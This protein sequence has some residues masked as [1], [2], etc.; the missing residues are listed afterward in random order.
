MKA[1]VAYT[2]LFVL[3]FLSLAPATYAQEQSSSAPPSQPMVVQPASSQLSMD[4]MGVR[5]YLL[6]PGDTLDVRVFGQPEMNWQGEVDSDGNLASLPFVEKPIRAQCRTDKD[7]EKDIR[8]AYAKFLKKP[9]VSV[10]VTGRNS[11]AP[12]LVYGA[13][14]VPQR[15]QMQRRTRL[16]EIFAISG[17]TTERSNG[18][19]LITH[20]QAILCPEPGDEAEQV[21]SDGLFQLS[22]KIYNVADL[23][24]GREDSNPYIRP[25]DVV[26]ALEAEPVYVNGSVIS[27]QGVFLTEGLRLQRALAMVGGVRKDAKQSAIVIYRVNPKGPNRE[28]LIYDLQAIK[29]GQKEDPLLQAYDIIEVPEDKPGLLK[30]IANSMMGIAPSVFSSLGTNLPLRVLY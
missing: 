14:Q 22:Y 5:R 30:T 12:A 8:E 10:R 1:T 15:V 13:F 3:T 20:T 21:A 17:G 6:G 2:L 4:S 19:I 26:Q 7:V 9:D 23:R 16:N 29:K 11:R 24:A 18:K 28:A 27:P 25:G